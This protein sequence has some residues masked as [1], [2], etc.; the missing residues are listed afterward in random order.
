MFVT[1]DTGRPET[2]QKPRNHNTPQKTKKI[3]NTDFTNKHGGEPMCSRRVCNLCLLLDT[4]CAARIV[5]YNTNHVGD[6]FYIKKN[7]RFIAIY[8][9]IFP[10]VH[11]VCARIA[12]ATHSLL[13]LGVKVSVRKI[14]G[15]TSTSG[16]VWNTHLK[17]PVIIYNSLINHEREWDGIVTTK[18]MCAWSY[19]AHVFRMCWPTS[20]GESKIYEMTTRNP[21]SVV[22]Y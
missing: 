1:Q 11:Q 13:E 2:T 8:K 21:D 10:N 5:K 18:F 19:V 9:W 16:I 15:S 22:L 12:W 17:I 7:R 14:N 4:R 20:E 6:K 3:R